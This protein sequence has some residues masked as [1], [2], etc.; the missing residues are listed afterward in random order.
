MAITWLTDQPD[1]AFPPLEHA[2]EHGLLAAGGDL[3]VTR[4]VAAYTSGIF[5]WFNRQDPVLWWSP[6]PRMVLYTDK[7]KVSKSLRKTIRQQ[8]FDLSLDQAFTEV[9]QA[10]AAPRTDASDDPGTWIHDSM[11]TAYQD[12]HQR[13]YAHSIECWQSG[14]LVGGLYGVAIGRVFFGESMFS[15]ERDASKVA[16][17][18]L[19][20]QLRRWGFPMIDCQMYSAHLQ[21]MGGETI[22]RHVFVDQLQQLTKLPGP[23]QW[24]LDADITNEVTH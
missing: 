5:P 17:T 11:I 24:Q 22:A 19:S 1:G 8:R 4:L 14:R 10:C 23:T 9:M 6:D 15:A 16:L 12:L 3:S 20:A 2:T 21:R 7:V 13:G 18:I